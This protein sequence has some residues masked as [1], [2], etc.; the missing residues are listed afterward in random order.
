MQNPAGTIIC[1]WFHFVQYMVHVILTS[2][3]VLAIWLDASLISYSWIWKYLFFLN[4]RSDMFLQGRIQY[5][6][7]FNVSNMLHKKVT[8]LRPRDD[9]PTING[10]HYPFLIFWNQWRLTWE[11]ENDSKLCLFAMM[12]KAVKYSEYLDHSIP[13]TVSLYLKLSST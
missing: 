1:N 6:I 12:N 9:Y 4:T 3:M 11:W 7:D 10:F 2:D 8:W 5:I 13:V